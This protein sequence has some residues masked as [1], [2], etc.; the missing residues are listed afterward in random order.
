[1]DEV[2]VLGG[3]EDTGHAG[4]HDASEEAPGEHGRQHDRDR[5]ERCRGHPE[6]ER[7]AL[8]PLP[9]EGTVEI[10]GLGEELDAGGDDPPA[11]RRMNGDALFDGGVQPAA[12]EV[13]ARVEARV[14][15]V[16]HLIEDVGMRLG[17]VVEAEATAQRGDRKDHDER[18]CVPAGAAM[19]DGPGRVNS[20]VLRAGLGLHAH[21]D[22]RIIP[23]WRGP[24][25]WSAPRSGTSR[26]S[27]SGPDGSWA[28]ST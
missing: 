21:R 8:G 4:P 22:P 9:L 18:S 14:L 7:L 12:P 24:C 26:T 3:E 17:E 27:R 20:A 23:L 1:M 6:A 10:S 5:P 15:R 2:Q 28:L 25:T 11:E 16:V 13:E 19:A